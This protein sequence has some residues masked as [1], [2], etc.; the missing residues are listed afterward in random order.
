M[1][2]NPASSK[3][4]TFQSQKKDK[5][6]PDANPISRSGERAVLI[7]GTFLAGLG[8]GARLLF[9]VADCDFIFEKLG[10]KA[11]Q[12]V[13]KNFK[14]ASKNKKFLYGLGSFAGLLALAVGGFAVLYTL[15]KSPNINYQSKVNTFT[16]GKDMDV[17][18]KGNQVEKELYTQMNEKA[19]TANSEEKEKLKAQYMQMHAAK[20]RMP[21]FINTGK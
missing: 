21:D 4:N 8:L 3:I 9:E 20:N 14:N 18:I 7:K 19:K 15:F 2:V 6:N 11:K 16:K 12:N 5:K 13:N 17:Y 10:D 1:R